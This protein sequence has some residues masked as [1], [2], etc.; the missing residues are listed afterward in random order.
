MQCSLF[1][2]SISMYI[3]NSLHHLCFFNEVIF[4]HGSLLHH[5]NGNWYCSF[6]LPFNHTLNRNRGIGLIWHILMAVI[7]LVIK[8]FPSK[9]LF[10]KNLPKF[11]LPHTFPLPYSAIVWWEKILNSSSPRIARGNIW[12]IWI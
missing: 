10:P 3:H 5:F 6:P 12:Q 11:P 7:S 8:Y 2:I 4:I 1:E 9:M